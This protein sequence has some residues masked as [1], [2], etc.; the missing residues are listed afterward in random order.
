[1]VDTGR[2]GYTTGSTYVDATKMPQ[3]IQETELAV[4][5]ELDQILVETVAEVFQMDKRGGVIA[6]AAHVSRPTSP[7]NEPLATQPSPRNEEE[8]AAEA[9]VKMEE[10][11]DCL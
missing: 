3:A 6:A 8:E 2:S 7:S 1:M 10:F 11:K 5:Q 4:A 9:A